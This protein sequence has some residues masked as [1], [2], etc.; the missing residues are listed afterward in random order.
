MTSLQV[1]ARPAEESLQN[2][3]QFNEEFEQIEAP[4]TFKVWY[5]SRAG[6]S[7]LIIHT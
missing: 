3:T 7:Q 4:V 6:R 5:M 1:P 2:N